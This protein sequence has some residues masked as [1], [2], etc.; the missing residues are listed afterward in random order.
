M[1]LSIFLDAMPY[2][3][4]I[5]NYNRW[6][7][8]I[9]I[10]KLIPNIGYS[11]SLHWQL[12]CNKYP[13]ETGSFVDWIMERETSKS[14]LLISKLL[15]P[16]DYFGDLGVLARKVLD[17]VIFKKNIFANIP[18]RFRKLFK[19]NAEY[20]FWN[21]NS[22]EKEN[23][24][25]DFVVI[26]Q[27][28]GHISFKK[29]INSLNEAIASGKKN[30]FTAM[31]FFDSEGHIHGR[32]T[33]YSSVVKNYLSELHNTI[34]SYIKLNPNEEVIL[35]SDHGMSNIVS[36][37]NLNL[38]KKIGKQSLKT[39]IAYSDSAIMSIYSKNDFYIMKIKE[40]LKEIDFGHLLSE[41]ERI[42]YGISNK[43]F[44]DLIFIL[45]EGYIFSDN[46]FGKSMRKKANKIYGMHGFWPEINA[47]D[48]MAAI[49]LLNS[50]RELEESYTYKMAY[51]L[52][53]SVM[54]ERK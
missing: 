44:G 29:V 19:E 17:R 14:V 21:K 7:D 5:L 30:I 41:D 1:P 2:T 16:L 27:D 40:Y 53:V 34:N 10:K 8:D 4:M 54:Q 38:T 31:G 12:Y 39:Y 15:S 42:F 26:S 6:F 32:T 24:F 11:S 23:I 37:V 3:E 35:I 33:T 28:E 18:F 47:E 20:L 45:K 25:Q 9:L 22:Y 52:L 49:I 46:W 50:N 43:R 51:N 48:Q 36:E 13:D